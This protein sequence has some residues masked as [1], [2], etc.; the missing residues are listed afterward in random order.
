MVVYPHG[1]IRNAIGEDINLVQLDEELKELNR[2]MMEEV[3]S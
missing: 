1:S 3:K 2:E